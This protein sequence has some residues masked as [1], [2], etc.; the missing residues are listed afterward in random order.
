MSSRSS[1]FSKQFEQNLTFQE[2]LKKEKQHLLMVT[3]FQVKF[4]PQLTFYKGQ[5]KENLDLTL[6]HQSWQKITSILELN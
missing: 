5:T 4:R 6:V 3:T 1:Y 2:K